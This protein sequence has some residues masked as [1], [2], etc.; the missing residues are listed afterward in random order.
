[1]VPTVQARRRARGQPMHPDTREGPSVV[2]PTSQSAVPTCGAMESLTILMAPDGPTALLELRGSRRSVSLARTTTRLAIGDE[3]DHLTS[4]PPR[5]VRRVAVELGDPPQVPRRPPRGSR[6]RRL[7][8]TSM[9]RPRR[10][11]RPSNSFIVRGRGRAVRSGPGLGVATSNC[12][13][14]PWCPC[15]SVGQAKLASL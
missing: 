9:P 12:L 5:D 2:S 4:E 8:Q 10:R 11:R 1:M 15:P 13:P 6:R 14:P 3:G 7:E